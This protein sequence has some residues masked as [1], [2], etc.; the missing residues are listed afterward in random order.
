MAARRSTVERRRRPPRGGS[1]VA[2]VAMLA[3]VLY[4]ALPIVQSAHSHAAHGPGREASAHACSHGGHHG[5]EPTAPEDGP[6][7]A[8]DHDDCRVCLALKLARAGGSPEFSAPAVIGLLPASPAR[9]AV[10]DRLP[11]PAPSLTS[12]PTRGPPTA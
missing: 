7:P 8:D 4:A 3:C 11:A 5:H 9:T 1:L 6:S 2:F 12:A 10:G